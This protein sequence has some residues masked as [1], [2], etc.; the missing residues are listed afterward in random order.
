MSAGYVD[1]VLVSLTTTA[2]TDMV[3]LEE[4]GIVQ[5]LFLLDFADALFQPMGAV[6]SGERILDFQLDGVIKRTDCVPF[7]IPH[8]GS[9]PLSGSTD[10]SG[11]EGR[12][13]RS[14]RNKGH[15]YCSIFWQHKLLKRRW[16]SAIWEKTPDCDK[17]KCHRPSFPTP[18]FSKPFLC[19]HRSP[20]SRLRPS[21]PA[22][23]IEATL[24]QQRYCGQ[25]RRRMPF[26]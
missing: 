3:H 17:T 18:K 1:G 20:I 16:Q 23:N 5:V 2:G 8:C 13:E 14:D 12:A 10:S 11:K 21:H 15:D 26:T 22:C 6:S 25:V 24:A 7:L 4:G 19:S 9:W